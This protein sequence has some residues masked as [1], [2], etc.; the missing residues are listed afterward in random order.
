MPGWVLLTLTCLNL[1][2]AGCALAFSRQ[3]S[4]A[5]QRLKRWSECEREVSDLRADFTSLLESHKRLRSR[6]GM[7][8]LREERAAPAQETK[9]QARVRVFGGATGPDFAKRQ[10]S[11]ARG[12]DPD[13]R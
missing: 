3:A 5:A 6:E 2:A 9:A 13:H 11:M 12:D 8:R 7:R 10:L 4:T 1:L